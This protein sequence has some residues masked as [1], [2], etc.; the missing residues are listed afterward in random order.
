MTTGLTCGEN[1]PDAWSALDS[2]LDHDDF[3]SRLLLMV[4]LVSA[5]MFLSVEVIAASTSGYRRR[6]L[7]LDT[8]RFGQGFRRSAR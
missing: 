3:L 4:V 8:A 6:T 1:Q 2:M 7:L 5:M